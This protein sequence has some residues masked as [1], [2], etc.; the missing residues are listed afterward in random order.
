MKVCMWLLVDVDF[1]FDLVHLQGVLVKSKWETATGERLGEYMVYAVRCSLTVVKWSNC[2][3]MAQ[4]Q[5]VCPTVGWLN[6]SQVA[7]LQSN[8]STVTSCPNYIQVA[9]L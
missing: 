7:Q 8:G 3:K 1:Q 6:Y 5:S 9:Q 2:N 4:L